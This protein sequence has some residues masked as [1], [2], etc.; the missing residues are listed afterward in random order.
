MGSALFIVTESEI[1]GFDLDVHGKSL[2]RE[3][4]KLTRLCTDLGVRPL[5][6]FFSTHPEDAAEFIDEAGGDSQAIEFTAE[7]W[8][9]ASDGLQTVQAMI[10]HIAENP[11]SVQDSDR[12]LTDLK[13]FETVLS[14]LESKGIRWHLGVDY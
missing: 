14:R 2:S 11:H 13:R 4:R 1:V 10:Q 6:E 8:F 7:R 5:M 3:E 9:D 12:V